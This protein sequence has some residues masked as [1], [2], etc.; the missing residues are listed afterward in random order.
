MSQDGSPSLRLLIFRTPF[1]AL[2]SRKTAP[3]TLQASSCPCLSSPHPSQVSAPNTPLDV[4]VKLPSDLGP[5]LA[6]STQGHSY[7]FEMLPS[8]GSWPLPTAGRLLLSPFPGPSSSLSASQPVSTG[9]L[10]DLKH[11][12]T[13]PYF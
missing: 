13:A 1:S 10:Q 2:H 7:H 4:L 6:A 3:F 8:L 12:F 5:T 11:T 9:S